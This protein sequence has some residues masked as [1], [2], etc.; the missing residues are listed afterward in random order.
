[1]Y[2]KT[3][4]FELTPE[5]Q[6]LSLDDFNLNRIQVKA[7]EPIPEADARWDWDWMSSWGVLSGEFDVESQIN[8]A[9]QQVAH[10]G[11]HL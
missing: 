1:R 11:T 2:F 4:D 10:A 6:A 9:V 8:V 5:V 3:H 7:P